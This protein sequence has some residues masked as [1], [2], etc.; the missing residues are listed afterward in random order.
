MHDSSEIADIL[1]N[2]FSSVFTL[3]DDTSA[4]D[5]DIADIN[6]CVEITYWLESTIDTPKKRLYQI[7]Y[8]FLRKNLVNNKLYPI[9]GNMV[10]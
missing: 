8:Y 9:S 5:S 6:I 10:T 7:T 4:P 3:W 2:Y 1:D